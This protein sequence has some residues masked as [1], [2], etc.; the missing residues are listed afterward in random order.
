MI[1]PV[2]TFIHATDI[3]KSLKTSVNMMAWGIAWYTLQM[4]LLPSLTLGLRG[5]RPLPQKHLVAVVIK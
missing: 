5:E 3:I 2:V 4:H 1:I